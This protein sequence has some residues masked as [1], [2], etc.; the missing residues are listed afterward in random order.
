[1][2]P[3]GGQEEGYRRCSWEKN[4]HSGINPIKRST[5]SSDA[6]QQDFRTKTHQFF[7]MKREL[8]VGRSELNCCGG[9][10]S[11]TIRGR[12]RHLSKKKKNGRNSCKKEKGAATITQ[13]REKISSA[14]RLSPRPEKKGGRLC[15]RGRAR[16]AFM[17][18]LV[19]VFRNLPPPCHDA[20]P[21]KGGG[22]SG[23]DSARKRRGTVILVMGG[24]IFRRGRTKVPY[25]SRA[26]NGGERGS[27]ADI[28]R[29]RSRCS[30][31]RT[32][33]R[34]PLFLRFASA[35]GAGKRGEASGDPG[36]GEKKSEARSPEKK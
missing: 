33:K 29:R 23:G 21:Q 27:E 32:R 9:T 22:S 12:G 2:H 35:P 14:R 16:P 26:D 10:S 19:P 25:L 7:F 34:G 5:S 3:S 13:K 4:T 28:G 20:G 8:M 24:E 11:F 36:G 18:E 30:G 17:G 1:M 6:R 31:E 15:R